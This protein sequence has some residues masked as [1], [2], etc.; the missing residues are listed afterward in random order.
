MKKAWALAVISTAIMLTGCTVKVSVDNTYESSVE[1]SNTKNEQ[2]EPVESDATSNNTETSSDVDVSK[3][4]EFKPSSSLK[5]NGIGEF[6]LENPDGKDV[7]LHFEADIVDFN[8]LQSVSNFG[9]KF[10]PTY[11]ETDR[12]DT[13]NVTKVDLYNEDGTKLIGDTSDIL[14]NILSEAKKQVDDMCKTAVDVASDSSVSI[15]E[16]GI[17]KTFMLKGNISARLNN[18]T[19]K[20]LELKILTYDKP[21]ELWTVETNLLISKGF[22]NYNP[23]SF[24]SS[25]PLSSDEALTLITLTEVDSSKINEKIADISEDEIIYISKIKDNLEDFDDFATS[26]LYNDTDKAVNITYT[27][28]DTSTDEVIIEPGEIMEYSWVY[29]D[30]L[31]AE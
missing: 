25:A 16:Y 24:V 5:Y 26:Y 6:T 18:D 27:I 28:S 14:D 7:T 1:S 4:W 19:G 29:Y 23:Y 11:T 21:E 31:K 9:I 10:I 13:F 30:I 8:K 20:V 12:E 3:L 15:S 2:G 22:P 17:D